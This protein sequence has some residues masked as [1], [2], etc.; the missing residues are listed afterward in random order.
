MRSKTF[1][2]IF[3]FLAGLT[4]GILI[5]KYEVFPYNAMQKT[6]AII[7]E[8]F[9]ITP[10]EYIESF[11]QKKQKEKI[12][13][14]VQQNKTKKNSEVIKP[15]LDKILPIIYNSKK[16]TPNYN[17]NLP[18]IT[19]FTRNFSVKEGESLPFYIHNEVEVNLDLYWL[20][21]EKTYI[22]NIGTIEPF[23]QNATFSPIR[24]FEWTPSLSLSSKNL[25]PGYYLLE[26]KNKEF[27]SSY[28]IPFVITSKKINSISF[29]ASTNTWNAYNN[30]PGKSFYVDNETSDEVKKF[31]NVL[32][33]FLKYN[34]AKKL[35]THIPFARPYM[36]PA[37]LDERPDKPHYSHLLRGEWSLVAF[38]EEHNL[39]YGVYT[40][41]EV[42]SN[43]GLFDSEIVVF[44]CH[45][46]YWTKDMVDALKQYISQGGKVVFA[47]G[48]NIYG[49]IQ[50]NEYGLELLQINKAQ[51]V[52]PVIGTF[53]G[54]VASP[55]FA[56]YKVKNMNHW[57]FKGTNI[58]NG[59]EFGKVS[60]NH[61]PEEE[62]NGASGWEAD[63]IS[64]DSKDF[65]VLAKGTNLFGA[66]DMVFKDTDNGGW[67]FNASSIPFTG[68]LFIDSV[69]ARIMINLLTHN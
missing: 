11:S 49:D 2:L 31:N 40:D 35:P 46:E 8:N 50:Y 44:N 20:G 32:N 19:G 55:M 13:V 67:V 45:N 18:K 63:Q 53:F 27:S 47:G 42:N 14:I 12:K 56:S 48:N 69:A 26:L 43:S 34:N 52:S 5:G 38:A 62:N 60:L 15:V 22:K 59:E 17:V 54:K 33:E 64:E 25:K 3:L 29:V 6:R 68:A 51:A 61:R 1:L 28:Q 10:F 23:S 9:D 36:E 41:R 7:K 37:I 21:R 16:I 58:K 39:E 4:Y 24:G 30:Y 57:V 66:A 65:I